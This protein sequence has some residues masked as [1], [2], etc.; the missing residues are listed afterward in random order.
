MKF[1]Q[2]LKEKRGDK[3]SYK[4][5][6]KLVDVSSVTLFRYERGVAYPS[7]KVLKKLC[8]ILGLDFQ[9]IYF[10]IQEEKAPKEAKKC[11]SQNKPSYPILRKELLTCYDKTF[12]QSETPASIEE[13][14]RE[15][16]VS[17]FHEIEVILFYQ[18]LRYLEKKKKIA[19]SNTYNPGE[20][21][22]NKRIKQADLRWNYDMRLHLLTWAFDD[23]KDNIQHVNLNPI[24]SRLG[25]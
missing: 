15:L 4:K 1:A 25:L 14:K 12:F 23:E 20:E 5:L 24:H 10:Q 9:K 13:I 16:S 3:Y 2:L 7:A 8:E 22:K 11:Y 6:A 17:A 19:P 18:T 21:A